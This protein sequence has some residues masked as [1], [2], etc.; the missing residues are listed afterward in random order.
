MNNAALTA[1]TNEKVNLVK[2][3]ANKTR[4]PYT[5]EKYGNVIIPMAIIRRFDCILAKKNK[6]IAQIVEATSKIKGMTPEKVEEMVKLRCGVPFYNAKCVTLEDL[7]GDS[8][9]LDANFLEFIGAYSPSVQKILKDL[10]FRE[11]V[12]FMIKKHILFEVVKAFSEVDFHPDTTSPIA[13]GYIFEEIIRTYKANAEA[14]DHYTPREVIKLCVELMMSDNTDTLLKGGR[15]LRVYDGCC[16]TGGMLTTL[17]SVL[18]GDK[19]KGEGFGLSP[20]NIKLYGQEINPEAYAI[21]CAEMLMLGE[22]PTNIREGNTLTE[23]K[24]SGEKFD[25]LITNPPFGVE[26]KTDKPYVEK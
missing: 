4:G 21:C 5:P 14:G 13:M 1:N 6:E 20:D 22:N 7:V 19:E 9:N 12:E 2:S 10:K 24:F 25:L 16:G 18:T 15:I 17:K 26:W 23:D 8:D 11:E 3:I